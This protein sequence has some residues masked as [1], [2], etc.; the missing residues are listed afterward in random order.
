MVGAAF[1]IAEKGNVWSRCLVCAV[2]FEIVTKIDFL[3]VLEDAKTRGFHKHSVIANRKS[4][5]KH[6]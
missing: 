3:Q 4:C 6:I 2:S 1:T 5:V